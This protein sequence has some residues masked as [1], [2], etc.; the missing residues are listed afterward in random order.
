MTRPF[1]PTIAVYPT[2]WNPDSKLLH[3]GIKGYDIVP[4]EK[5]GSNLVFLIDVS[6]SMDEQDKLPLIKNSLRLLVNS[7]DEEDT[8]AIVVYAGAAGTVLEPTSVKEKCRIL[9]ALDQMQAGGST[10]GG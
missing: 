6:G 8:V 9:S 1:Q 5:P 7:L 3:I 10:A 2:P 4:E